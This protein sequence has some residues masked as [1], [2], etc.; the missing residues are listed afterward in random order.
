MEKKK[1]NGNVLMLAEEHKRE[2]E[3]ALRQ[4]IELEKQLDKKH[5]LEMEIEE[6]E[7]KLKV[8]EHLGD[9]DAVQTEIK[10][11]ND[12]LNQKKAKLVDMEAL[13][14][15]LVVKER[16]SNDELQEVRKEL[17]EGLQTMLTNARTNIGIKRM[18]ELDVKVFVN[19]CLKKFSHEDAQING[20]TLCSLWQDN[21][22]KDSKWYPFKVIPTDNDEAELRLNEDDEKL[23]SLKEQWG[24]DDGIYMEV[25]RAL[26]ELNEYNPSGRYVV[27]ELWNFKENRKATLKEVISY[28]VGQIKPFKKNRTASRK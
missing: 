25:V 4:I 11:L 16:Q 2:K 10:V 14:Q 19:A 26:K 28:I 1:A 27:P 7:G 8:R 21:N 9:D 12:K 18:G 17:I 15:T 23:Q 5:L 6:L 13:N 24:D 20:V 22:L 3:E